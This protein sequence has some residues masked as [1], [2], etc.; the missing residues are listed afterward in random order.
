MHHFLPHLQAHHRPHRHFETGKPPPTSSARAVVHEPPEGSM[1]EPRWAKVFWITR[2]TYL[3][4]HPI[5]NA[6]NHQPGLLIK[7]IM[8]ELFVSFAKHWCFFFQETTYPWR[9]HG[10][11]IFTY[12]WKTIKINK[13]VGKYTMTM[14]PMKFNM[15]LRTKLG[16]SSHLIN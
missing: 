5:Q 11:G 12:T 9:I 2:P 13:Q 1:P 6:Q 14:D 10:N 16:G 3:E 4:D 8:F 7:I 15:C